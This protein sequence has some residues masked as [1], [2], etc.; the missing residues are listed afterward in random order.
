[1]RKVDV[2]RPYPPEF[3]SARTLAYLMDISERSLE[4]DLKRGFLPPPIYI[5]NKRRWWWPDV[6]KYL[7]KY[8]LEA[9]D[10]SARD[11]VDEYDRGLALVNEAAARK[12]TR[13]HIA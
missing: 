1:M 9:D 4:D 12:K 8:D 10:E 13:A 6:V 7:L 2:K 11:D 3:V 5:G